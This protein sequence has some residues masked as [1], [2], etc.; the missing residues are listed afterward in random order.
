MYIINNNTYNYH[1]NI[2]LQ[3]LI[4][5]IVMHFNILSIFVVFL[6]GDVLR[7]CLL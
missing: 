1:Y 7:F 2:V 5:I 6:N 4:V 3:L